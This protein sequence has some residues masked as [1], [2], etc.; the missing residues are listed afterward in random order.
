MGRR[1]TPSSFWHEVVFSYEQR[2]CLDGPDGSIY[3][4]SKPRLEDRSFLKSPRRGNVFMVCTPVS[5][6]NSTSIVFFQGKLEG[7]AYGNMIGDDLML[8]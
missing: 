8:S 1:I 3:Y 4:W 7:T 2:F 6:V 5:A